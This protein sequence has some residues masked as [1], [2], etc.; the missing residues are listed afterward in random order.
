MQLF[1]TG[2]GDDSGKIIGIAVGVTLGVLIIIAIVVI[3]LLL[4]YKKGSDSIQYF[5][6]IYLFSLL[7]KH[8]Q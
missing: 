6:F 3:V 1:V 7:S 2:G 8:G 4:L 5:I